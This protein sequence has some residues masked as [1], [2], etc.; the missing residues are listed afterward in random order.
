MGLSASYAVVVAGDASA[1]VAAAVDVG[2]V[3][4]DGVHAEDA[5][6]AVAAAVAA[7]AGNDA[8]VVAADVNVGDE[9]AVDE[10]ESVNVAVVDGAEDGAVVV[11]DGAV[12]AAA[13][14]A[15]ADGA[16]A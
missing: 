14:A 4:E 12:V 15:A 2:A 16:Y 9:R 5:V 10:R 8:H 6:D 11:G 13:V 3:A 1:A 7:D